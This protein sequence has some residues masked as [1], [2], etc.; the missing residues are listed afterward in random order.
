MNLQALL[1]SGGFVAF[2]LF[3][4]FPELFQNLMFFNVS[5]LVALS[6]SDALE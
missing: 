1:S 3:K 2:N 6:L 5:F 4:Q